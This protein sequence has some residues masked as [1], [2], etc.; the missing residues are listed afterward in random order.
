MHCSPRTNRKNKRCGQNSARDPRGAP[1]GGFVARRDGISS[2]NSLCFFCV[3]LADIFFWAPRTQSPTSLEV[4]RLP[5]PA[6]HF[7]R[8]GRR[9][10]RAKGSDRLPVFSQSGLGAVSS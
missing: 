8:L 1:V 10:R 7:S 6:R 9:C 5:D 3:L 2:E 4:T